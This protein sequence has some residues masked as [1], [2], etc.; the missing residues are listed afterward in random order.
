MLFHPQ[1]CSANKQIMN[2]NEPFHSHQTIY[3]E[4]LS[5][6]EQ[7][8]LELAIDSLILPLVQLCDPGLIVPLLDSILAT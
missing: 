4:N 7:V 6:G 1:I 2:D 8:A 5:P 3:D